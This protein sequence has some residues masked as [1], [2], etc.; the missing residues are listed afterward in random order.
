MWIR[1]THSMRRKQ[2]ILLFSLLGVLAIA[3]LSFL[4]ASSLK[5]KAQESPVIEP[6]FEKVTTPPD[7]KTE[8]KIAQLLAISLIL[9]QPD[10]ERTGFTI[11]EDHL[12]QVEKIQP[13]FF[14]IFGKQLSFAATK[15]ATQ[16]LGELQTLIPTI[17][18][19][20]HEGGLVQRLSGSGFTRIP[21]WSDF[22][23][24]ASEY[25]QDLSRQSAQELAAAGIQ[26]ILGPVIDYRSDESPVLT[27]RLCYQDSVTLAASAAEVIAAYNQ[28]NIITTLKHYPGI[29][30]VSTDLHDGQ[31]KILDNSIELPLFKKLLEKY[32]S[33]AVM[34]SHATAKEG[35][36]PCSLSKNCVAPIAENH[37][38]ALIITDDINM[39]SIQKDDFFFQ[40]TL[41]ER[42][43]AALMAK[44]TVVMLGTSVSLSEVEN[45]ILSLAQT[46]E[47][48]T[49][50][51]QVIDQ[52][53]AKVLLWKSQ[54]FRM[55]AAV[56]L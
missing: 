11:S 46:Y 15:N 42:V 12:Q 9:S 14:I 40:Q 4:V 54:N 47:Q 22:C 56:R 52:S 34:T 6:V 25:R 19:V 38:Q 29:G 26:M 50:F 7:V 8:Q 51:A 18:A 10:Y 39:E 43:A 41:S 55:D 35:E 45:L 13:G 20:D 5:P 23:Q 1:Q 28:E 37:P 24:A 44:N 49:E 30:S 21:P 33:I 3:A 27:S 17:V 48:N 31:G 32:P 16:A 2:Y 36:A 53:F